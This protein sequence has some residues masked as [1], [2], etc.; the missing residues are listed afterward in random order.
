[1]K[2]S[3]ACSSRT[4]KSAGL[5]RGRCVE[6]DDGSGPKL[7]GVSMDITARK[8]AEASAALAQA[9]VEQ[10]RAELAHLSR[11]AALGELTAALGA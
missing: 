5:T 8:Q 3:I 9:E 4:E 11:V 2:W 1:M 10:K 7:F 6:S